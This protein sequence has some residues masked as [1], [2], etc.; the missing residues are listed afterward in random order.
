MR[1]PTRCLQKR[2]KQVA[3]QRAAAEAEA[4]KKKNS[5]ANVIFGRGPRGGRSLGEQV[6]RDVGPLD[7]APDYLRLA[8]FCIPGDWIAVGQ[9][10][11]ASQPVACRIRDRLPFHH[12]RLILRL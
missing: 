3:E 9:A 6:T 4:E 12:R 7:Y 11:S 10:G 5:W 2:A 1:V 8:A